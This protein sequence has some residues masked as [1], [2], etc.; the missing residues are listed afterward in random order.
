MSAGV[1]KYDCLGFSLPV[2]G[3]EGSNLISI[4]LVYVSMKYKINY[5]KLFEINS[6]SEQKKKRLTTKNKMK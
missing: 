2:S 6:I 1:Y 5:L 4:K 3:N